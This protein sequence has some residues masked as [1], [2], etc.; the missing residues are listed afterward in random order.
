MIIYLDTSVALAH[1]M[2]E[3]RHPAPELWHQ[4]LF[5]SRLLEYELWTRVHAR[6][7]TLSHGEGVRALVSRVAILEL[8]PAVL[9]RATEPFPLAL[10]TLD[11]LHLA[12]A[13]FLRRQGQSVELATYDERMRQAA[14]K[15]DFALT[16]LCA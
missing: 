16:S 15:L 2:A 9:A 1:L 14:K 4:Q 12:S 7:L 5:S 13:D 11:V 6:G 10:R 3:D 8:S